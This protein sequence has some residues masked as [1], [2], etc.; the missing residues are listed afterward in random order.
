MCRSVRVACLRG[1]DELVQMSLLSF[2][3]PIF[4]IF[5]RFFKSCT[6]V[7]PLKPL[8]SLLLPL[9]ISCVGELAMD[10]LWSIGPSSLTSAAAETRQP[11]LLYCGPFLFFGHGPTDAVGW[12]EAKA[13]ETEDRRVMATHNTDGEAYT[14]EEFIEFFGDRSTAMSEW[15]RAVPVALWH[16]R[17]RQATWLGSRRVSTDKSESNDETFLHIK[18]ALMTLIDEGVV[19]AAPRRRKVTN[20]K[21]LRRALMWSRFVKKCLLF[22]RN[23]STGHF[24]LGA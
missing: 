7:S 13:K 18:R 21:L 5:L 23:D 4:L 12:K 14:L 1:A 20:A 16:Q 19:A 10:S 8:L 6:C 9:L 17:Q 3:R 11:P 2:V 15:E 24:A 22:L